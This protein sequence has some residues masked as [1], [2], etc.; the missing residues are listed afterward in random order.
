MIGLLRV[1][2]ILFSWLTLSIILIF[3]VVFVFNSVSENKDSGNLS[4]YSSKNIFEDYVEYKNQVKFLAYIEGGDSKGALVNKFLS[5][6]NSPMTQ[7]S[8]TFIKAAE[9]YNLD[10]RLL[11][12]I[13]FTEST[14]GKKIPFG[15]FNAFGW[16]T[17]DN[18][19]RGTDFESWDE[20]IFTVAKGLREDYYNQGLTTLES[21]NARY[22]GDENWHLK[23]K[24]AMSDITN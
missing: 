20:A 18:T 11:P 8:N 10:W 21:I 4:V 19:T 14:L 6:N 23:V 2:V 1:P 24:H 9:K 12:A 15:T 17:V 16:G 7:S 22:A 5:E 13:A 3:G